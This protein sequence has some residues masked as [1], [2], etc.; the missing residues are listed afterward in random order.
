MNAALLPEEDALVIRQRQQQERK[1]EARENSLKGLRA[2]LEELEGKEQWCAH[3]LEQLFLSTGNF[4]HLF[5]CSP[6]CHR[7]LKEEEP[8]GSAVQSPATE[9]SRQSTSS[10]DSGCVKVIFTI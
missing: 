5:T 4:E 2:E 6:T 9:L 8:V 3:T 1:K 10:I 7:S